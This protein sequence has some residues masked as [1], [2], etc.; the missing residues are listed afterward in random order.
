MFLRIGSRETISD[1][2][3]DLSK[4]DNILTIIKNKDMDYATERFN[5][6]IIKEGKKYKLVRIK[7]VKQ[8]SR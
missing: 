2:E 4:K 8:I 1:S 5:F 3:K 6:D 7:S